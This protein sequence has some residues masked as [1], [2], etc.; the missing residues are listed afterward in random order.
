[1]ASYTGFATVQ[2]VVAIW[3]MGRGLPYRNEGGREPWPSFP[4]S[5]VTSDWLAA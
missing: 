4:P 5:S 1:M 3:R 2:D